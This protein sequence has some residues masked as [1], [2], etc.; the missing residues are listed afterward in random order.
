MA[1]AGELDVERQ[2]AVHIFPRASQPRMDYCSTKDKRIN[3]EEQLLSPTDEDEL[4]TPSPNGH[5]PHLDITRIVCVVLV[6]IDHD[7]FNYGL[8]DN[9]FVQHWV[10]QYL[11]LVCG[12]CYAMS[13]RSL[14]S[15]Q[16]RLGM[17]VVI[18]IFVNWTAW[19]I[20]G[21]DW[22][23]NMFNVVFQLWF[24]VGLMFY[25]AVLAPLK[26]WLS[27]IKER[28]RSVTRSNISDHAEATSSLEQR[29]KDRDSLLASIA[30]IG[31]G[32][33]V[34][35]LFF[36]VFLEP[37][38]AELFAPSFLQFVLSFGSQDLWGFPK[39]LKESKAFVGDMCTYFLLT[40]SNIYLV[41]V[42]PRFVKE[43][44]LIS[45]ALIFNTYGHRILF[46]MGSSERLFHGLDLM[47]LAMTCYFFGLR[48]RRKIG[49]YVI[50]YWF[51]VLFACA[52]LWPPGL[53]ERLDEQPPTE[54]ELRARYA[55]LE[56]IFVT[57]WLVAGEHLV[58][59]AIFEEDHLHFLNEWT[60]LLFLVHKAVHLML[61]FPANWAVLIGLIPLVYVFRHG[62]LI[63]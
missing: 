6:A 35:V 33:V 38:L 12:V 24:V 29:R 58:Q 26:P 9:C 51:V 62:L 43:T 37:V 55:L 46:F 8:W 41:I 63:K 10:L 61:S 22:K 11:F 5:Y 52:I 4:L 14:L 17:Y 57:V 23:R 59:R 45:W 15:Y 53:R 13:G 7:N 16:L 60:L 20:T 40:C 25:A 50:R 2:E 44:G 36:H 56:F 31:G 48:H 54:L 30:V 39:D 18:G 34:L 49:E 19:V 1:T 42:G 27:W 3:V 47:M 28:N 32:L 21:R